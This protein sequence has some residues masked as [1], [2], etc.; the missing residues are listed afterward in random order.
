MDRKINTSPSIAWN[1]R[2]AFEYEVNGILQ[3]DNTIPESD[4]K[5][6]ESYLRMR[7][8]ELKDKYK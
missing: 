7:I 6:I 3:L 4:K 1:L 2:Y 8:K 5:I